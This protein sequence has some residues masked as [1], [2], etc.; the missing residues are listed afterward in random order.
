MANLTPISSNDA[1]P[2]LEI[3]T[4]ALAGPGQVM[5]SQAQAVLNRLTFETTRAEAA[6]AVLQA[7]INATNIYGFNTQVGMVYTFVIGD[8]K[9]GSERAVVCTSATAVTVTIPLNSSVNF[10]LGTVIELIQDGTGKV[11]VAAA[12]GVTINSLAGNKSIA[13]QYSRITIVQKAINTWW[14]FGTLIA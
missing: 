12:G 14:L 13:G 2:Q 9:T 10:P 5:N 7:N 4:Q 8:A 3:T 6:E 1:V 11:T